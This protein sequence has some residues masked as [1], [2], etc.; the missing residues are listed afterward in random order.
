MIVLLDIKIYLMCIRRWLLYISLLLIL[1][2]SDGRLGHMTQEQMEFHGDLNEFKQRGTIRVVTDYNAINYFIYKGLEIGYQ[3]ELLQTMSKDLGFKLELIISND[4]QRNYDSLFDGKVDLI[5]TNISVNNVLSADFSY[6]EPHSY[7]RQVLVQ[8]KGS[9]AVYFD[10]LTHQYNRLVRNQ[11]DLAKKIVHVQKN[12]SFYQR[13]VALQSEIGDT[14]S[15]VEEPDYT[16]EQLIA[17]VA[18]GEIDY[19]VCDENFAQVNQNFYPNID[20]ETAISF[21]QKIAWVVRSNSPEFNK[22]INDWLL[23]FRHSYSYSKIYQKY[24][25]N[26]RTVYVGKME[27]TFIVDNKVSV[28]DDIL[29]EESKLLNW[30]WRLLASLVYQESRF[31]PEAE[32]W[33]GA[34]GLMQLMPETALRFGVTSITS[35][36]DNIKGGVRYLVWLQ[37]KINP[38]ISI[39]AERVKFVLASYN[40]G[41]GHVLDAM[42]LAEKYGKNPKVWTDNVDYYMLNKSLPEFYNDTIVKCGYCRGEEPYKYVIEVLERYEE[43]KKRLN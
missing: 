26:R 9:E 5:A 43:F 23:R 22:A 42:R 33:A 40:A 10:S 25:V 6:T 35:P 12:S 1:A 29:K 34:G 39:D 18:S 13:L 32:S 15:I 38:K 4:I 14:I 3:Y 11:L 37:S 16:V 20:I 8:R 2:C 27:S 36:R 7:S 31:D 19:T 21:Q 41:L 24:F 17:L 28:F 30:D